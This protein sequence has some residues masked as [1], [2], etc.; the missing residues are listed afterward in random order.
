MHVYTCVGKGYLF[1]FLTS[2]LL[3]LKWLKTAFNSTVTKIPGKAGV[4][5]QERWA[6]VSPGAP[7]L[8]PVS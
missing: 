2:P 5:W 3:L 4:S 6:M 7:G 1:P 8:S